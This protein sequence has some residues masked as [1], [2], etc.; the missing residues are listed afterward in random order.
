V[1]VLNDPVEQ[2]WQVP[3]KSILNDADRKALIERISRVTPE[4]SRK[5]GRMS[6]HGMLCHL[7]DSFAGCLGER[8]VAD[9]TTLMGRTVMRWV[10]LSTPMPWPKGVAT[11]PEVDQER[12][13]TAPG[14]FEEDLARLLEITEDF[15]HRIDP[16]KLY[17]PLFG[18]LSAGEWGR[19]AWRHVDHH[20]RQFGL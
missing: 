20:T 2:P 18:R 6:P 8:E 3:M 7:T 16:A 5:W 1:A 14:E 10:A 15:A 12:E 9:R 19:W 17:H 11:T 13:G 4:T